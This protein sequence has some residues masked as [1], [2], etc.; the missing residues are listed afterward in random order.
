VPSD[1]GPSDG[2]VLTDAGS[3]DAAG[4]DLD[5]AA[6]SD[7]AAPEAS[8]EADAQGAPQDATS[9]EDSAADVQEEVDAEQFFDVR[10]APPYLLIMK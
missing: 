10:P 1:R 4:V 9:P 7:E 6:P 3:S 5:A 2:S 8:V